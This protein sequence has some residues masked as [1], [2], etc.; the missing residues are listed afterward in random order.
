MS[1][2]R[3]VTV[4]DG[5]RHHHAQYD[6]ANTARFVHALEQS[7]GHHR[8]FQVA[9]SVRARPHQVAA[10]RKCHNCGNVNRDWPQCAHLIWPHCCGEWLASERGAVLPVER[11]NRD[12][13]G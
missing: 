8:P 1:V 13:G 9:A 2:N 10:Q 7:G 3:N 4:P 5:E 6:T 12:A 11:R